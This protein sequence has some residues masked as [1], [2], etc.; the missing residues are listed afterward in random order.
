MSAEV[1]TAKVNAEE[2]MR[3]MRDERFP[4]LSTKY[5]TLD[6]ALEGKQKE[7]T[8]AMSTLLVGF[9]LALIGIYVIIAT[10]F[11]SYVQPLVIMFTVPFGI[12]G[13]VYGHLFMD[14][15]KD[16]FDL[17]MLSLF[18]IVALAGVVVN[19]AIV[20][21]E[22]VNSLIAEGLPFFE[23]IQRGGGRRFRAIFLTTVSTV[24]G[25]TP[26]ILERDMQA[27]F[28]IPMAVSI[29]SGV[30]FATLLTLLLIPCL[31][32]IVNDCR[33]IVYWLRHGQWPTPEEVEP[34]GTATWTLGRG[35]TG[36][37]GK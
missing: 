6:F 18:G 29:A 33:R 27:Q 25:L 21:I 15:F 1:D 5:P 4:A 3:E 13:A 20:L 10:I 24:G 9:P 12:I 37:G 31:L 17:T 11:R 14:I 8:E 30:A 36:D 23:A 7:N 19:D 2:V 35:R 32:A 34:A 28:L 26:M 22:C 16:R